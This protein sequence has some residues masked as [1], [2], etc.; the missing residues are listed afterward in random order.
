MTT[1]P[2]TTAGG[3]ARVIR[4][5]VCIHEEDAGMLWKHKDWRTD[6]S[7]V[8]GVVGGWVWVWVCIKVCVHARD[9]PTDSSA[10]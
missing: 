8:S 5:A 10:F 7:E 4:N 9:D 6:T 3:P 2:I 1:S